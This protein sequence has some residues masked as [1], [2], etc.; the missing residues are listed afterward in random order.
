[1]SAVISGKNSAQAKVPNLQ[2]AFVAKN[3]NN[4]HFI[5]NE[6]SQWFPTGTPTITSI[7]L[8][9]NFFFFFFI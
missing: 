6:L 5:W 7:K 4:F 8:N 9:R 1:L 2:F 3:V